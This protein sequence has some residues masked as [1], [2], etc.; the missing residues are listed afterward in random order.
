[1]LVVAPFYSISIQFKLSLDGWSVV[2]MSM[3]RVNVARTPPLPLEWHN[4]LGPHRQR[5]TFMFLTFTRNSYKP[6]IYIIIIHRLIKA[7]ISL[8]FTC[9]SSDRDNFTDIPSSFQTL[10]DPNQFDSV[11][12]PFQIFNIVF[13]L[14][15]LYS[16]MLVNIWLRISIF[17]N[18]DANPNLNK[19]S[20]GIQRYSLVNI[21]SIHI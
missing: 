11:S 17:S 5:Q 6:L 14:S 9:T 15:K 18:I 3:D 19:Y 1:M 4:A 8:N 7:L 12:I 10:D 13:Y 2:P 16:Y 21:Q 20:L